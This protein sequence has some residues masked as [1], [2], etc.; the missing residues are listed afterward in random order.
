MFRTYAQDEGHRRT[1]RSNASSRTAS[2]FSGPEPTTGSSASTAAR[3][4]S[5]AASRACRGPRIYQL[6]ETAD[7]RLYVAPRPRDSR[8]YQAA[9]LRR[10]RREGR[11]RRRSPS[12]HQGIASD[13]AG[14]VYVGTDRGLFSGKDDRYQFDKEANAVGE[15]A[16]R[17]AC[18]WTRRARCISRAAVCSSA[19][20]PDASSSSGG[21]A[22]SRRTRRSGRGADPTATGRLWVRTVK[23]LY[24][25]AQGRARRFERDDEGLPESSEVGPARV[26]RPGRAA[27]AD[28]AGPRVRAGRRVAPD[29]PAGGPGRRTRRSSALVD[30]EGSLWVGLLGGGLD[31]RLG[32]GEFTNWTA[33]GRTVAGGRLG[34]SRG[35]SRP[36]GPARSGSGTEQGLEPHRPATG[37]RP[38]STRRATASAATRSTRSPRGERRQRLDR[39]LA[40]AA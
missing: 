13:A 5:S 17:R 29:R 14:T 10:R 37:R 33:L 20:S 36:R 21:R 1:S 16:G 6:H 2:A 7:G 18:T 35:R 27:R 22:A 23:H 25:A 24:R 34:R 40:R 3:F 30:R 11:P 26:R 31:R 4:P 8:G 15:G 39:L 28:G 38:A 19:R 32:R 9:R 12:S